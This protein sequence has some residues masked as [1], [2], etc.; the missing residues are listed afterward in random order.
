M[1]S[2]TL[3][4]GSSQVW[5]RYPVLGGWN[6][7]LQ[8]KYKVPINSMLQQVLGSNTWSLRIPLDPPFPELYTEQVSVTIALPTGRHSGSVLARN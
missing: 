7:D 5:P 6:F 8:V 2:S 3:L 4:L 1:L